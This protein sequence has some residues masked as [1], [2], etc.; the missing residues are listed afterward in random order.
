MAIIS[1]SLDAEHERIVGVNLS[2]GEVTCGIAVCI[3]STRH[4][5]GAPCLGEANLPFGMAVTGGA[6]VSVGNT[7]DALT[8][9]TAFEAIGAGF[10]CVALAAA[11]VF[12][13]QTT[14]AIVIGTTKR[15]TALAA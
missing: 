15:G 6:A 10:A 11:I 8:N 7:V 9:R 5:T 1:T 3:C 4:A 12:A 14:L 13:F 2:A